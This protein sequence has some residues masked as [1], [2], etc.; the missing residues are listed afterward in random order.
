MLI[1]S[2]PLVG[3]I[4]PLLLSPGL[5][6]VLSTWPAPSTAK[7]RQR[8]PCLSRAFV[9]AGLV[10]A[11]AGGLY[12]L[13]LAAVLLL[14]SMV[15]GGQLMQMVERGATEQELLKL[16]RELPWGLIVA[17]SPTSPS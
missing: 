1:G 2:V 12:S 7:N 11:A 14:A 10:P 13:A 5:A 4:V 3:L 6:L 9:T 8:P 15:G 17:S 16:Q